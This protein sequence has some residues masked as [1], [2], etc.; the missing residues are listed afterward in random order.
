MRTSYDSCDSLLT[1]DHSPVSASFLLSVRLP[2]TAIKPFSRNT[3]IAK[4]TQKE[5]KVTQSVIIFTDLCIQSTLN[6]SG[7]KSIYIKFVAP[8]FTS[9]K[10]K[11]LLSKK[12]IPHWDVIPE[13]LLVVD[14]KEYIQ[15][16]EVLLIIKDTSG[17]IG[18]SLGQAVLALS[19]ACNEEPATFKIPIF[20]GGVESGEIMGKVHV[21]GLTSK[22]DRLE[23]LFRKV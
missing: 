17:Q 19:E 7:E 18:S 6:S 1:S 8:F 22:E 2:H 5:I 20:K 16:Q 14:V 11:T 21:T 12:A 10:N 9:A 13:I 4:E 23:K 3:K 15:S